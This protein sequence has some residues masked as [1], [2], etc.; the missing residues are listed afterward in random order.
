MSLLS[1]VKSVLWRAKTR[2]QFTGWLQYATT[3]VA[4]LAFLLLACLGWMVGH[5]QA[6]LFWPPLVIAFTL[7]MVFIFD[8]CTLKLGFRPTEPLPARRDE[9]DAFDLMRARR[10]CRS[11]QTR[12]LTPADH[13]ELMECVR[14]Q[15]QQ[16]R[17]LGDDP[18]RFEFVSAQ[19]TVWPV[20]GGQEFLVAIAPRK[21]CRLSIVDVG[22]SLQKVVLQ[23]TRMG[24]ATCWIGPGADH[25]SLVGHLGA[26]FDPERD[27]IICVC[28]VGYASR[29]VPLAIRLMTY[30]Q[31]RRLPLTSLFFADPEFQE[32]LQTESPPFSRFGRCFEMC[33]WSPSSFNGQPTRVVA[34]TDA[35]KGEE[36]L[37]RFDFCSSG[38]SRFYAPVALGIWCANWESGCDAIGIHGNFCTLTP[39][40][41]GGNGDPKLQRCDISWVPD[42]S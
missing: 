23:A 18:V 39:Q 34:I 3:A 20:V 9:L 10:S 8:V 22:R 14:I 16:S 33:R 37:V 24:L 41:P 11:F 1:V 13:A 15:S 26:R 4:A 28:A 36:A 19:L 7:F 35:A 42:R 29:L 31:H 25:K 21:Y 6:V 27:H 5:L 38:E 32:P 2:L 40:E 17:L 30:I 12:K